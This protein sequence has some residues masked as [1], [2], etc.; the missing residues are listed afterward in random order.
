MIKQAIK[1]EMIDAVIKWLMMTTMGLGLT[2]RTRVW[3]INVIAG[4]SIGYVLPVTIFGV[5]MLLML[6]GTM[7]R[8]YRSA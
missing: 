5:F 7:H 8:A 1:E 3:S 2:D 4:V 6:S